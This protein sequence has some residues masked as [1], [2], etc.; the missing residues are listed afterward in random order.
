MRLYVVRE[1]ITG[2]QDV[3][4]DSW[5][6]QRPCNSSKPL[7][8]S[9]PV[10]HGRLIDRK[11]DSLQRPDIDSHGKAEALPNLH[12]NNQGH[13]PAIGPE[14]RRVS[15]TKSPKRDDAGLDSGSK[16]S[17]IRSL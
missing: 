7:P 14:E 1:P 4:R 3:H 6:H 13:G 5:G 2:E 8:G 15:T 9:D 11:R 16:R 12:G 10:E 17:A